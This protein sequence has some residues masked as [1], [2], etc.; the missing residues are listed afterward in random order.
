MAG[1]PGAGGRPPKPIEQKRRT[2]NP[3]KRQLPSR[4]ETV[5]LEP[6]D[7]IPPVPISLGEHGRNL[8]AYIWGGP[9]KAWLSPQVDVLR[10]TTV[11]QLQDDIAGYQRDIA[12]MDT[13]LEE[14]I[15]TPAGVLAGIRIVPNP[16][17]K[18]RNDALKLLDREQSALGF[19]PVSRSRL[20]L[21]E[22]K[23]KSKLEELLGRRQAASE[24]NEDPII[25]AEV[26][27]IAADD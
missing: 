17:I 5:A 22:V 4:R 1:R 10:V 15:V 3:G 21:A 6:A 9:A 26:I 8:W 16:L 20:G 23:I 18:L 2:G 7:G 14:P 27:D 19:D 12:R 13:L 24:A 25:D 11:C